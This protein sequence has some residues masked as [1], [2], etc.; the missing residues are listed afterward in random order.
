M[1]STF[2]VIVVGLGAMG[3]SAAYHLAKRGQRVLGLDRY[4]P[5]HAHGSTHG[6]TRVFREAYFEHP[7]YV[8]L[9]R[10]AYDLW[11]ALEEEAGR[12]LYVR[13]G[14]LMI[15][16]SD[17]ILVR[18]ALESARTHE[19]PHEMLGAAELRHRLPAFQPGDDMVALLEP[20][21]GLLFPEACVS[22]TL[23]LAREHGARLCGG[24]RVMSWSPEGEG[25][26]VDTP[27]STYLAARLVLAAGPWMGE[28]LR[29]LDPPLE[30]ERQVSCWFEP[31]ARAGDFA[32]QRCPLALWEYAPGQLAATFP[33]VGNGVKAQIHHHGEL[34]E[35]ESVNRCALAEDEAA[36]RSLLRRHLPA[37]NGRLLGATVCLYTNT[38][39]HHFILD[40]HPAHPQV[41][42]V[43]PCSGHGFKFASVLGEVV[44]GLIVDGECRFGLAAF[45]LE[46]FG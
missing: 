40:F 9:L 12:A 34:T 41:L 21:A 26:R 37:A 5:P 36:V 7:L 33:D 38:P 23:G 15:G 24:E 39:D 30:V 8:P 46:R 22:A 27:T 28:L 45:G 10:R 42:I 43:S 17:G 19:L 2:D 3:S 29:D 6:D 11:T 14:G 35:P 4:L 1:Q 44:A 13:T 16:P 20:R 31:A 25:V 32:P 18:G